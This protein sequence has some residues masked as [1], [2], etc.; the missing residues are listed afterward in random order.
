MA[1]T[2]S[3]TLSSSHTWGI[4]LSLSVLIASCK[5]PKPTFRNWASEPSTSF[6]YHLP[7]DSIENLSTESNLAQLEYREKFKNSSV[8]TDTTFVINGAEYSV[9]LHNKFQNQIEK[10]AM[11]HA[12]DNCQFSIHES[13]IGKYE[14]TIEVV[15]NKRLQ[16]RKKFDKYDFQDVLNKTYLKQNVIA[17]AKLYC[18]NQKNN[19]FVFLVNFSNVPGGTDWYA[20]VYLVMDEL[21]NIIHK[22]L[23]DYP[24]HCEGLFSVTE[25]KRYILTCSEFLDLE[26]RKAVLFKNEVTFAKFLNDTLYS[27]IYSLTTDSLLCDTLAYYQNDTLRVSNYLRKPDTLSANAFIFHVKGDTLVQFQ[28]NGFLNHGEG[29]AVECELLKKLALIG[30]YDYKKKLLRIYDWEKKLKEMVYSVEQLKKLKKQ[31]NIIENEEY[32]QFHTFDNSGTIKL[33]RFY[34]NSAKR[35]I[36]YRLLDT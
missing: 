11:L 29:Y 20:Q 16:F 4:L 8:F 19:S 25:D 23:V 22:G 32:M 27:V 17:G 14:L 12:N 10:V 2:H 35:V 9:Y 24:H 31:S 36:G 30:Y 33:I 1:I 18:Y 26:E 28:F 34:I 7:T 21:G 3:Y 13:V 5:D 15:K 6:F